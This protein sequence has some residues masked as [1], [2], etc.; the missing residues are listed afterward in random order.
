M[1]RSS[2]KKIPVLLRGLRYDELSL[3]DVK[4]ELEPIATYVPTE[5]LL[6]CGTYPKEAIFVEKA[7]DWKF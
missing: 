4:A 5:R 2:A 3:L 7:F 1:L 6:D